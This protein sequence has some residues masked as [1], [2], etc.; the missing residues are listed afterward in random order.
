MAS[1]F[2]HLVA[3]TQSERLGSRPNYRG[4]PPGFYAN[5]RPQP[6]PAP[7]PPQFGIP[8]VPRC[9]A[10]PT[11]RPFVSRPPAFPR[12]A[13]YSSPFGRQLHST[14]P[15]P[16]PQ[17]PQ[18]PRLSGFQ[19]LSGASLAA[20][21]NSDDYFLNELATRDFSSPS[22]SHESPRNITRDAGPSRDTNPASGVGRQGAD[23][24][25][26]EDNDGEL[27]FSPSLGGDYINMPTRSQRLRRE[28]ASSSAV[29]QADNISLPP[30]SSATRRNPSRLPSSPQEAGC[31]TVR[32]RKRD[33]SVKIEDDVFG[34]DGFQI[35]DLANTEEVP[36]SILT[37]PKPKKH[38][39][40]SAFQCVICMD[41]VTDL[42]VTHCGTSTGPC[43]G[44]LPNH[45]DIGHL[46][47]GECLHSSL[48][49]DAHKKICP[50]CRQ[51][52][53]SKPAS[54]KFG[55]RARGFYPLELKLTTKKSL[56]KRADNAP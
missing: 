5:V 42:T 54:G 34:S 26:E 12:P 52:I 8:Q 46:F 4:G 9:P 21:E 45:V 1:P 41:D 56:G 23:I 43:L 50:I 48:H 30:A 18:P 31:R 16:F 22:I 13:N 7:P 53:D 29:A 11:S 19:S 32:K 55:P 14:D 6:G 38:I 25:R 40:L 2:T 3:P 27:A 15:T 47:C 37:P 20:S 33:E 28:L 51:K 24:K 36:T 17:T 39:R 35:I 10:Y 49:I 44:F